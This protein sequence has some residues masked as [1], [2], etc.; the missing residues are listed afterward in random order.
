MKTIRAIF[1]FWGLMCALLCGAGG[2]YFI[3]S[4]YFVLDGKMID[5]SLYGWAAIVA[6]W[7]VGLWRYCQNK[8][9]LLWF[10]V[11][12]SVVTGSFD[13]YRVVMY[14]SNMEYLFYIRVL[15]YV[16]V[17]LLL[18][19]LVLKK[20]GV[21]QSEAVKLAAAVSG[22]TYFGTLLMYPQICPLQ[23]VYAVAGGFAVL[24]M[25]FHVVSAKKADWIAAFG[26]GCLLLLICGV[27]G[28]FYFR[29]PGIRFYE[30]KITE[31]VREVKVSIIIP[32]Y[33]AED[34]IER[35]LDSLR[36]QTLKE[37]EIIAV[38]DGST[39]NTPKIL[40]EYA[41]HDARIKVVRQENAYVGAARNHGIRVAKGEY[42]GF[43]DNDDWVS[44]GYYQALYDAAKKHN[45]D[46]AMTR[47]VQKTWQGAVFLQRVQGKN[48]E[49]KESIKD[50]ILNLRRPYAGF[51]WNKIYR[52]SFLMDNEIFFMTYR[53]V[54]EDTYFSI[55]LLTHLDDIAFAEKGTYYHTVN[56][57]KTYSS[58]GA[59]PTDEIFKMFHKL[60]KDLQKA[61]VDEV[62]RQKGLVF[63]VLFQDVYLF[64][65]Y[66]ALFDED[67]PSF[68]KRCVAFIKEDI[69]KKAMA[70]KGVSRMLTVGELI[71]SIKDK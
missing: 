60:E 43:V 51:V 4:D 36:K 19:L 44:E 9:F 35:C 62:K 8:P 15:I 3:S 25:M 47:N 57:R 29:M 34:V 12:V 70:D 21:V 23:Y 11:A 13:G 39:D 49:F 10:A 31:P 50:K 5:F 53:T 54:Y 58:S 30:A 37:I 6:L 14:T 18:G 69:C 26:G 7:G 42:V 2:F 17:A 65:Y 1:D 38:D 27:G 63:F 68:Y 61:K 22:L 48:N 55:L 16:E 59:K 67:K 66:N 32:V 46:V 41:A 40:A 52:R 24:W 71:E 33:N 45:H 64:N 20:C 56:E 28:V